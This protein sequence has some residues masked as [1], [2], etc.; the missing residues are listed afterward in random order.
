VI[1]CRNPEYRHRF[2]AGIL[3]LLRQF[4]CRNSLEN[5]EQWPRKQDGLLTRDDG[6][7]ACCQLFHAALASSKDGLLICKDR[8]EPSSMSG[9]SDGLER[10][11]CSMDSME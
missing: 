6:D 11:N 3:K 9:S 1:F 2:Y 8:T 5:A 10:A 7:R 4:D